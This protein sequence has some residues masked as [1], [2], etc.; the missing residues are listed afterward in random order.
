MLTLLIFILDTLLN[1]FLA[2]A[3]DNLANAQELTAAEEADEKANEIFDDS[4]SMDAVE[5]GDD[6]QQMCL[7][8]Q[9]M[10]EE[11]LREADG[12]FRL[13]LVIPSKIYH[14]KNFIYFIMFKLGI[15]FILV[16]CLRLHTFKT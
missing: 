3:V 7:N 2:I 8:G 6:N 16:V 13:F 15:A 14:L 9:I 5:Y 4:E 12:N 1:V 11:V 10:G